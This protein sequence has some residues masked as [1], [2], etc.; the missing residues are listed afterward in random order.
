ML[1]LDSNVTEGDEMQRVGYARVSTE[2]QNLERQDLGEVDRLFS[3]KKSGSTRERPALAEMVAF[4]RAGDEVVVHSIDRLAR[5]LRD[6]EVIITELNSKGVTV[7]FLTE[8]LTFSGDEDDALARLQLQ[9][10]GAFSQ[11]ERNIIRKRQAEGI[12]KAKAR[13]VYKGRKKTINADKVKDMKASGMRVADIAR[14]LGI[15]R[16]SVYRNL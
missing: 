12:A 6:L 7:S 13:G 16:Q 15:S 10:M 9:I 11:F 8:R 5:D 14:D 1:S 3:E 4:V 2:E